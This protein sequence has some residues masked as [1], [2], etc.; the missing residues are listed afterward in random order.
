[1]PGVSS[2]RRGTEG[3]QT[4]EKGKCEHGVLDNVDWFIFAWLHFCAFSFQDHS[5]YS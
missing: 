5:L 2:K 1:M 4:G 3:E